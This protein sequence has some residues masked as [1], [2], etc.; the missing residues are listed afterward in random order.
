MGAATP[1]RLVCFISGGGRTVLNLQD[2]IDRGELNA[3]IP[4][5]VASRACAGVDRCRARGIETRI[6]TG[7]IT[8]DD[9]HELLTSYRADLVCLAGYLRLLPVPSALLT[10]P[11]LQA[12]D[13]SVV[14]RER[15]RYLCQRDRDII[16]A[17]I[18]VCQLDQLLSNGLK[19]STKSTDS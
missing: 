12:T 16:P 18:F 17:S 10:E 19:I 8:E 15:G 2:T 14:H 9:L 6:V 3:T 1:A 13:K 4:L 7:D 11:G 5:V